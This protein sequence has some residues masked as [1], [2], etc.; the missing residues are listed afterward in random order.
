MLH[1]RSIAVIAA[2]LSFSMVGLAEEAKKER[3][4]L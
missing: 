1:R 2:L 4:T 3:V